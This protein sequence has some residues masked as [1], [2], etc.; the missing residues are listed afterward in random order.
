MKIRTATLDDAAPLAALLGELG[1]AQAPEQV[2]RKLALLAASPLD[3][4]K[5]AVAEQPTEQ[6][7]VL[8]CISL[9]ALPM[10]HLEQRLGRITALVVTASA[11]GRGIGQALLQA[12]HQW[13]GEH[14]CTRCELTSGDQR[15]EA[16]RFYEAHGY[17]RVSQRFVR[18]L[19][20]TI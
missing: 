17:A 2:A 1:Y 15:H 6:Q 14:G 13:F 12:A 8:G 18:E 7:A 3:T 20:S 9:H 16:H 11:R 4:V 19:P 5:V 10:F